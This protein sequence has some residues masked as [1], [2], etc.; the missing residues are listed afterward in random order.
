MFIMEILLST[1][2]GTIQPQRVPSRKGPECT[3]TEGVKSSPLSP[4]AE[5]QEVPLA[6]EIGK[7]AV[8]SYFQVCRKAFFFF[9]NV[10]IH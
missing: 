7:E 1:V 2:E 4:L 10:N 9:L 6:G 8:S 3:R 5:N